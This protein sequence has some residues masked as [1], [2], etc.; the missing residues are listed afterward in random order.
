MST[1][2]KIY[3]KAIIF[4]GVIFAALLLF[5]TIGAK[6]MPPLTG[7][8]QNFALSQQ[9][10]SAPPIAFR[11]EKGNEKNV[12]DF[13][14][15]VLLV[16]FWATWCAPCIR[17]L[18][19]LARLQAQK[20]GR[21]FTVLAVSADLKGASVAK[22]FLKR[23]GLEKLPLYL[24][25]EMAFARAFGVKSLPTT[26]LIDKKGNVVGSLAGLAEWDSAEVAALIDFFRNR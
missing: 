12:S 17:E 7:W 23:H 3:L 25:P 8:L 13:Q 10:K 2:L 20:G 1:K 22:P 14:G 21:N 24:D 18:P 19:S 4:G 16:N 9:V 26:I 5:F 6:K 11:D 15:R